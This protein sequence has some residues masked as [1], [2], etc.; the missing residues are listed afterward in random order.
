MLSF[1][2]AT[3]IAWYYLGRQNLAYLASRTGINART[4][5]MVYMFL[6]LNAVFI[7]CIA[8]LETVWELS[9]IWNGL[10]AVPNVAALFLL[11]KQIHFPKKH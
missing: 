10:M 6:Y 9:D 4:A 2:F 11:R 5:E 8:R 1:A 3:I 7:G